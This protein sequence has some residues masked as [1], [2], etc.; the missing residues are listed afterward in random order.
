MSLV[1]PRPHPL[2]MKAV[3]KAYA[4]AVADYFARHRVKPGLTGWA[5]VHGCRGEIDTHDKAQRRVEHD[6]HYIEN[7]S[8]ALDAYIMMRT[9]IVILSRQQAY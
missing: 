7:W 9:V 3:D 8:I 5:Q 2:A 1:G 6:L 4:D